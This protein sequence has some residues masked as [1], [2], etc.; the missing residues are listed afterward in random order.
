MNISSNSGL[1]RPDRHIA[2]IGTGLTKVYGERSAATTAISN[3]SIEIP[4]H[5]ISVLVGPSGSGKSTLLHLL[6]GLEVPTEGNVFVDGQNLSDLDS[7]ALARWRARKCGFVLQRNNLIP[8]LTAAENV[9]APLLLQGVKRSAAI[10]RAKLKLAELGIGDRAGHWP[11]Q[12][13][14]GEASRVAIARAFVGEPVV[15][16]ADEPTGALDTKMSAQVIDLF[17]EQVAKTGAAAVVVTHDHAVTRAADYIHQIV[18][19][20]I[21]STERSE[22]FMGDKA[23]A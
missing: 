8:T 1:I 5:A 21:V 11:G 2:L 16:F 19:G 10:G 12:L 13:S 20:R 17:T 23:N 7:E 6:A 22:S 14:G 9:A 15:I 18:D 4:S 3:V